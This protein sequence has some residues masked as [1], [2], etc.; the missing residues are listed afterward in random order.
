MKLLTDRWDPAN[1]F[2]SKTSKRWYE[3]T[4]AGEDSLPCYSAYCLMSKRCKTKTRNNTNCMSQQ[5]RRT[6][7][8]CP[9]TRWL[10][11]IH[12][13]LVGPELKQLELDVWRW[14]LV[15]DNEHH[16]VFWG[17]VAKSW[18]ERFR[19]LQSTFLL[20]RFCRVASRAFMVT[21]STSCHPHVK[22]AWRNLSSRWSQFSQH[23][24]VSPGLE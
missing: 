14:W 23:K 21:P 4:V 22:L 19:P 11:K 3:W 7:R 13:N 10:T 1:E 5:S 15:N 18:Q 8:H 12:W 24:H 20:L 16:K 2:A 17:F 6:I 9:P